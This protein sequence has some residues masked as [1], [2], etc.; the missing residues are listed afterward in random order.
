MWIQ[1]DEAA[2]RGVHRVFVPNEFD[3]KPEDF[4]SNHAFL[5]ALRCFNERKSR[6]RLRLM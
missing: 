5:Q 4:D 6:A 2:H 1:L 3:K